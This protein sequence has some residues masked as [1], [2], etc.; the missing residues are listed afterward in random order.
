MTIGQ[1]LI[2]NYPKTFNKDDPVFKALIANTKENGAMETILNDVQSFCK[3][4]YGTPDIYEQTGDLLT[5]TAD[6]YTYLESFTDELEESFK[7]RIQAIFVRKGDQVWGTPYNVM[8]VFRQ[9]FPTAGIYLCENV[10]K[11]GDYVPDNL[12][13]TED[14]IQNGEFQ[15]E[16]HWTYSDSDVRNT[17]ARFSKTYGAYL[18][19]ESSFAEQEVKLLAEDYD[20]YQ[21]VEGDTYDS[22]S[23]YEYGNSNYG[24]Y[25]KD[26]KDNPEELTKGTIL[27]IPSRNVFFLHFFLNGSCRV[28]LKNNLNQYWNDTAKLWQS[29]AI[30]NEFNSDGWIDKSLYIINDNQINRV[31]VK[32]IGT[33]DGGF[34]DYVRMFIKHKHPSFCIIAHFEG[35]SNEDALALADGKEDTHL[36]EPKMS[37]WGY[38]DG[39][40]LTGVASGYAQDLYEDLLSYVKAQGVKAY[41]EIVNRDY[42]DEE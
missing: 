37:N 25:I 28:Q 18:K 26:Y 6:F 22:I 11:T 42:T 5:K 3:E 15:E 16:L 41:I 13:L 9:Y 10:N 39:A 33:S 2:R 38:Y 23:K 29:T 17:K 30:T 20:N 35:N 1:E 24:N 19:N 8:N 21:V 4:Y 27:D 36:I 32:F 34:V 31:T 40:F 12:K 7:K 14:F